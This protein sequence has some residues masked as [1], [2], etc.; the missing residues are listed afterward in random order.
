MHP[1][2]GTN[3]RSCASGRLGIMVSLS[4]ASQEF[5]AVLEQQPDDSTAA[6]NAALCRM[7]ACDLVG[8]VQLLESCLKVGPRCKP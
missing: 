2:F 7:Y 4:G 8:A 3:L 5:E 6:N 1:G